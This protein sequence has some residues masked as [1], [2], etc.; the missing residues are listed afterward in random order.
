MQTALWLYVHYFLSLL[1]SFNV[2]PVQYQAISSQPGMDIWS[3]KEDSID[4]RISRKSEM[5]LKKLGVYCTMVHDSVEQLVQRFEEKL[6]VQQQEWFEQYVSQVK[7]VYHC[8]KI[9]PVLYLKEND[10]QYYLV[11]KCN[12]K[13]RE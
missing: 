10:M 13:G 9:L 4:V 5:W 6:T 1:Y 2:S 8:H 3:I 11:I 7:R 12:T